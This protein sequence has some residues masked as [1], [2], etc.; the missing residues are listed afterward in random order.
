MSRVNTK[1]SG[2]LA[3]AR[4]KKTIL[5]GRQAKKKSTRASNEHLKKS[6]QKVQAVYGKRAK[7]VAARIG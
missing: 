3:Y 6:A 5:K 4:E 7:K 1:S 2:E